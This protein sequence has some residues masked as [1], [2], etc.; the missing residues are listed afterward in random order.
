MEGCDLISPRAK[1]PI[2]NKPNW[3]LVIIVA[4]VLISFIIFLGLCVAD[5]LGYKINNV[6]WFYQTFA[7]E[8][9]FFIGLI[10]GGNLD[11]RK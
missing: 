1:K 8:L 7:L 4:A 9:S 2:A 3:L 11:L 10:T 5:A 6:G